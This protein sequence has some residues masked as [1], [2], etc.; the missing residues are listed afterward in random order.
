MNKF[1]IHC[2]PNCLG[3]LGC[4]A[5]Y[6]TIRFD[7]SDYY[8]IFLY[9]YFRLVKMKSN[10]K[11]ANDQRLYGLTRKYLHISYT[12]TTKNGLSR[13][14]IVSSICI[15]CVIK[16]EAHYLSLSLF[17]S[18]SLPKAHYHLA[19]LYRECRKYTPFVLF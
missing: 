13:L 10:L 8:L 1:Q 18:L 14:I 2:F 4:N 16:V 9:Y 19:V 3:V 6:G 11:L 15:S 17:L 5:Y 7:Y 12:D